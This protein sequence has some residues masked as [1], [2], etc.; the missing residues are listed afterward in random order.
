VPTG[1]E[2][3]RR[4]PAAVPLVRERLHVA[5]R[6]ANPARSVVKSLND[7]TPALIGRVSTTT[8]VRS[9]LNA[10]ESPSRRHF[11]ASWLVEQIVARLS[12]AS[13]LASKRLRAARFVALGRRRRA[14]LFWR[15]MSGRWTRAMRT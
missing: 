11:E 14:T 10:A 9:T 7:D 2:S 6:R 4:P 12:A 15:A 13:R 5:L 3:E 1:L 8:G